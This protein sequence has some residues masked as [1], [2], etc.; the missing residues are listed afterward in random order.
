MQL[1]GGIG[2]GI[3][4]LGIGR[5]IG[6]AGY[7]G[8]DFDAGLRVGPGLLFAFN[9]T[10]FTKNTRFNLF[11]EPFFRFTKMRKGGRVFFVEL[12]LQRPILR[13]GFWIDV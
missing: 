6:N 1:S 3:R 9:E 7:T 2:G 5:T 13:A 10:R 11:I 8:Y 12:G 4:I